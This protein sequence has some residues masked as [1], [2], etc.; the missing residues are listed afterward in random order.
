MIFHNPYY[1][2]LRQ[3]SRSL[4]CQKQEKNFIDSRFII[5][6]FVL[7]DSMN[8]HVVRQTDH[9]RKVFLKYFI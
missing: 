5:N 6:H 4:K 7:C 1:V 8:K 3:K 9:E 2:L